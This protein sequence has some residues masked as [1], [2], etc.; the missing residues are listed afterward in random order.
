MTK[1]Y[2][3]ENKVELELLPVKVMDVA[4]P[5]DEIPPRISRFTYLTSATGVVLTTASLPIDWLKF[6]AEKINTTKELKVFNKTRLLCRIVAPIVPILKRD[7]RIITLDEENNPTIKKNIEYVRQVKNMER[8]F[9]NFTTT[10]YKILPLKQHLIME[11]VFHVPQSF[12]G[13][14]IELLATTEDILYDAGYVSKKINNIIK[15]CEN[16]KVVYDNENRI[17]INLREYNG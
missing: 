11:A 13:S 7:S 16:C 4:V 1:T 6:M 14:L 17:E 2:T 3:Q 8:N 12:S 10:N 5:N 15:S 9:R